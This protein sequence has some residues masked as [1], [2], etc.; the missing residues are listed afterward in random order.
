MMDCYVKRS[1]LVAM[2]NERTIL[3]AVLA[4]CGPIALPHCRTER[5]NEIRLI[6]YPTNFSNALRFGHVDPC[7][8]VVSRI[9]SRVREM[10]GSL[11][12]AGIMHYDL[13]TSNIVMKWLGVDSTCMPEVRIIDWA[14][15][16]DYTAAPYEMS[17]VRVLPALDNN[18]DWFFFCFSLMQSYKLL[19]VP[20]PAELML[21]KE[22]ILSYKDRMEAAKHEW[23]RVEVA[24]N[25]HRTK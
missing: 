6:E 22:E 25:D 24:T 1:D 10:C 18:Y 3:S 12:D 17:H 11:S 15:G 13:H 4:R 16:K 14:L 9:I 5:E 20:L 2:A 23:S 8:S 7:G 19:G 21:Q